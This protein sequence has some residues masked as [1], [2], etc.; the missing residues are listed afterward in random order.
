MAMVAPPA[1]VG[2]LALRD[3]VLR[4]TF[5]W[6]VVGAP[7]LALPCGPAEHGLPASIQLVGRAG[8]DRLVLAAG[9]MLER[10]LAARPG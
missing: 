6:N 1:G 2:D 7:A 9:R 3:A 8:D 10:A 4:L 5:P